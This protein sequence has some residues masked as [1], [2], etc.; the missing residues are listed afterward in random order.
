ML[1]WISARMTLVLVS[2]CRPSGSPKRP[3][4]FLCDEF[5]AVVLVRAKDA[6]A[7]AVP[8]AVRDLDGLLNG[9]VLDDSSDGCEHCTPVSMVISREVHTLAGDALY[10][11][12][13]SLAGSTVPTAVG[14]EYAPGPSHGCFQRLL[15]MLVVAP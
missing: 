2:E 1:V 5:D 4:L 15:P 12:A 6:R 11:C 9:A 7:E 3:Y 8:G 14:R 13:S 10:R